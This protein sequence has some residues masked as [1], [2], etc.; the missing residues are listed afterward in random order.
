MED[1]DL[2]AIYHL[3]YNLAPPIKVNTD[4]D[5]SVISKESGNGAST[6]LLNWDTFQKIKVSSQFV[7][8]LKKCK[9][10]MYIGGIVR[11]KGVARVE[12]SY[13]KKFFDPN[14]NHQ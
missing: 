10:Q 3:S 2:L 13:Q 7:S 11:P 9:L 1:S 5:E 12:F 6:S 14:Y 8:L 4:V